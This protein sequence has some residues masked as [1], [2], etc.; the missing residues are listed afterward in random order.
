MIMNSWTGLAENRYKKFNNGM[1]RYVKL[2]VFMLML[3]VVFSAQAD[4]SYISIQEMR[5]NVPSTWTETLKGGKKSFDCKIEA[6]IV[7]PDVDY[8]PVLMVDYQGKISGLEKLGYYIEENTESVV[9]VKSLPDEALP[10]IDLS[11]LN[12]VREDS[13]SEEMTDQIEKRARDIISRIYD[14][15]GTELERAGIDIYQNTDASYRDV[16]FF[17]PVYNGIAYLNCPGPAGECK[18]YV[19]PPSNYIYTFWRDDI[20]YEIAYVCIPKLIGELITDVPLLSF[21]KIQDTIRKHIQD[22]YIQSICEIR[23]GYICCNNPEKPEE[24]F[25]LTPAWVVCGVMNSYPNLPFYPENYNHH[26]RYISSQLIINA[27]TGEIIDE[28]S[29]SKETFDAHILTWDDVKK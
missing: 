8:F 26:T 6:P 19:S 10:R 24:E 20:E 29:R 16:V 21:D 17:C 2:L 18:G 25:Y 23:L 4:S 14:L 1:N 7:V 3:S 5:D 15:R 13:L 27:Q 28:N 9:K 22:G 12:S 11:D